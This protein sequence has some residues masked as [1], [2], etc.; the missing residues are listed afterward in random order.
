MIPK[1]LTALHA[2]HESSV[3]RL[4]ALYQGSKTY[5]CRYNLSEMSSNQQA[6][7]ESKESSSLIRIGIV[8]SRGPDGSRGL[9]GGRGGVR[10]YG[11]DVVQTAA[12]D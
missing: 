6:G 7:Q 1:G 4:R 9:D 8:R 2:S 3:A 5:R 11:P 10:G 12:K